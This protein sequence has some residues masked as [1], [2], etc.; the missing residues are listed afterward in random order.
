VDM[1]C[2]VDPLDFVLKSPLSSCLAFPIV[3]CGEG[4][5]NYFDLID[6]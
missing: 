4:F 3:L 2:I 6:I 1:F 5:F